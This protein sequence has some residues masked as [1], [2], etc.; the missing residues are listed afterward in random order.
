MELDPNTQAKIYS[1]TDAGGQD[2]FID[3][4]GN[5]NP[6]LT[7]QTRMHAD[8][9]FKVIEMPPEKVKATAE[10]METLDYVQR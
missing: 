5:G 7:D 9:K 8:N 3:A 4:K 6:H 1:V 2:R 10:S